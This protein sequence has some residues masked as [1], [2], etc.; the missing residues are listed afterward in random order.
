M[1]YENRR[2]PLQNF[3]AQL[4]EFTNKFEVRRIFSM[5]GEA[6]AHPAQSEEP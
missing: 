2:D 6:I 4:E 3:R 5:P 1:D